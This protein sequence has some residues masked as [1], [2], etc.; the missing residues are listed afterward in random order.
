[1]GDSDVPP[2]PRFNAQAHAEGEVDDD[3]A[4]QTMPIDVPAHLLGDEVDTERRIVVAAPA[5]NDRMTLT[6]VNGMAAGQVSSVSSTGCILGRSPEADIFVD[7]E[8][9]SRRHARVTR[10]PQGALLEDLGSSNGTFVEG[11]RVNRTQ[12]SSGDRVQLGATVLRFAV[13]DAMEEALKRRLYESSTRDPLTGTFNRA[14]LGERLLAETASARRHGTE[15]AV[16][17]L[18]LDNF[19]NVNDSH[20]HLAGDAVLA[21]VAAVVLRVVRVEDVV[22]R[23]GG[24]E[25]VVLL[26][27]TNLEGASNLA[28]RLR[29]AVSAERIA[30]EGAEL[31]VTASLGVAAISELD[32][33]KGLMEVLALADARLYTAKKAGRDR[34]CASGPGDAGDSTETRRTRP[35]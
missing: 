13:I 10:T 4:D 14:Y 12:L 18:D 25:F 26:R 21:A 9:V 22:A 2:T 15:L 11:T 16:V 32:A 29:E 30:V 1:M 28:E 35:A 33:E 31:S 24:E 3:V 19:K 17:M 6:F 8:A 20:G 5:A 27:A 34:V 7:D 23:Y